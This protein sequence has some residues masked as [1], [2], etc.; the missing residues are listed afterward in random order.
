MSDKVSYFPLQGGE[1]LVSPPLTVEPGRLLYSLNYECDVSGRYHRIAGFERMDGQPSPSDAEYGILYFEDGDTEPTAGDTIEGATSGE[2]GEF[3]SAVVSSGTFAGGDAAGYFVLT[4]V[5]DDFDAA[6]DLEISAVVIATSVSYSAEAPTGTLDTTYTLAAQEAARDKIEEVP[7]S[8]SILGVNVFNG[9]RYAFRNNTA[10]TAA[11]MYKSTTS[12]WELCGLGEYFT[13]DTGSV[14][15]VEAEVVSKGVVSA[16]VERVVVTSGA[17]SSSDAAGYLVI[18][19]RAGGNF[20][21]GA[22]TGSIAGAANATAAQV[23]NTL[24]ASGRFEIVNY[25]FFA[26]SVGKRMYCCDGVSVP[27]EWDGDIFVPILTS[28]PGYPEHIAAHKLHLFL[29]YAGGSLQHSGIGDPLIW[30]ALSGAAELGLGHDISGM[31]SQAGGIL[32]IWCGSQISLLYGTSA[33]DWELSDLSQDTG[34]Q[35]WTIQQISG[36]AVF[37]TDQGI[38]DLSAVQEYGDFSATMLSKDIRPFL[39]DK[40]GLAISSVRVRN[41]DQYRLFFSDNSGVNFTLNGGFTRINYGMPARCACSVE[42]SGREVILFGSDDGF[43]YQ[44]EKGDTFDGEDIESALL[45]PFNHLKSPANKKRFRKIVIECDGADEIYFV[46]TFSYSSPDYPAPV[47][48]TVTANGGLGGYW[49]V[50]D[51]NNFSWDEQAV[52]EAYAQ[53][54]GI[55]LNMGIYIYASGTSQHTL[56]GILLHYDIRGIQR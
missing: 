53:I 39:E 36:K 10:G 19:G 28:S 51:W 23:A 27:F 2:T 1:D 6:E 20:S 30:T 43:V 15:F 18:S 12:G 29:S 16:T 44:L 32:A 21:A 46:P 35:A 7:G 34:A 14:A 25:N 9:E 54:D 37:M 4:Q 52:G 50:A 48:H 11:A 3:L 22:I 31:S 13:F 49:N 42:E 5:S 45:I 41:K 8:G 40:K 24:T 17:W 38:T 56:Q 55:G 47:S 26:T 33:A